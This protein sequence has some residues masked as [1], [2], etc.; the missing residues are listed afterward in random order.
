VISDETG[1]AM[2]VISAIDLCK[3]TDTGFWL[4]CVNR[5]VLDLEEAGHHDR[6]AEIRA[7]LYQVWKL[8]PDKPEV[9]RCDRCNLMSGIT[10]VRSICGDCDDVM[11][12]GA[13]YELHAREVFDEGRE[14]DAA[15]AGAA[16]LKFQAAAEVVVRATE[17]D[18]AL[19]TRPSLADFPHGV[20]L[21]GPAH[22]GSVCDSGRGLPG[23]DARAEPRPGVAGTGGGD[24]PAAPGAGAE[25]AEG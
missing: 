15:L 20:D 17:R 24:P 3:Q 11:L 7:M 14:S 8:L 6:V 10:P 18:M 1:R 12:C 5:I 21:A 25:R 19:K 16:L 22:R 4:S 23:D 9:V 13:C 2:T